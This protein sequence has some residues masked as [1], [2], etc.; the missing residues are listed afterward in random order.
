M[1]H[2]VN[3]G[4][5][6][7]YI[8]VYGQNRGGHTILFRN[9]PTYGNNWRKIVLIRESSQNFA[10]RIVKNFADNIILQIVTNKL[11]CKILPVKLLSNF[12]L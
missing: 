12:Y 6:F 8:K 7:L 5:R 1:A 11:F 10:A 2:S 9:L 3:R 4:V